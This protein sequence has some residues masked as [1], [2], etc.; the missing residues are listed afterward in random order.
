MTKC[1]QCGNEFEDRESRK[2]KRKYCGL[3]CFYASNT[4][5]VT[6]KC[7]QC[8][9]SFKHGRSK[10][11]QFCSQTCHHAK[12]SEGY[13]VVDKCRQCGKQIEYIA[14]KARK[15]CSPECVKLKKCSPTTRALLS[16]KSRENIRTGK[17]KPIS[18]NAGKIEYKGVKLDS[19]WELA[20]AKR[21]DTLAISWERGKGVPWVDAKGVERTYFPDFY[22]PEYDVYL[23]PKSAWTI[24]RRKNNPNKERNKVAYIREHYPN[25]FFL[26]SKKEC[27]S[28]DLEKIGISK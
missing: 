4:N 9:V 20:L 17:V 12:R 21:L 26:W 1:E 7:I 5:K 19:G 3:P 2:R 8:G 13:R 6:S 18:Y 11:R 10:K 27:K 16:K 25:V 15:Y 23:E 22:L 28:F 24:K 14:S